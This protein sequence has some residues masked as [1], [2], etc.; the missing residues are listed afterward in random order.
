M[1]FQ[2]FI[3]DAFSYNLFLHHRQPFFMLRWQIVITLMGACHHIGIIEYRCISLPFTQ[4]C[5]YLLNIKVMDCY[6]TISL[7]KILPGLNLIENLE[8]QN[9]KKHIFRGISFHLIIYDMVKKILTHPITSPIYIGKLVFPKYWVF[10]QNSLT[11][12]S[13]PE[14]IHSFLNEIKVIAKDFVVGNN[15]TSSCHHNA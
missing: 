11:L 2:Y 3:Y 4:Q 10:C 8:D 9:T 12:A 13:S 1:C 5:T 7:F 6:I 14:H 15:G